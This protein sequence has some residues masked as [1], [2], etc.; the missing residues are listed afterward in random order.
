M[1]EQERLLRSLLILRLANIARELLSGRPQ[2]RAPPP[3]TYADFHR[4]PET[5]Q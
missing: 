1:T 2:E 5:I 3:I 4:A